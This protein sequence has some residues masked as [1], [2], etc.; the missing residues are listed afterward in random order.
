MND[1]TDTS[2]TDQQASSDTPPAQ[3]IGPYT[4]VPYIGNY[5]LTNINIFY[6]RVVSSRSIIVVIRLLLTTTSA[7]VGAYDLRRDELRPQVIA[8]QH[9]SAHRGHSSR[10]LG[11]A[12]HCEC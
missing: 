6:A 10:S 12:Y 8:V 1:V 2:E 9:G 7:E 11:R 5:D 3:A 4:P